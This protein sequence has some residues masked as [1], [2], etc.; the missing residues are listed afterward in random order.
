MSSSSDSSPSSSVDPSSSQSIKRPRKSSEPHRFV[1][2]SSSSS[3]LHN[4]STLTSST[5]L[6]HEEEVSSLSTPLPPSPLPPSSLPSSTPSG[7]DPMA[8]LNLA[9]SLAMSNMLSQSNA[10]MGVKAMATMLGLAG[11]QTPLTS[12][13]SLSTLSSPL[14]SLSSLS[15]LGSMGLGGGRSQLDLASLLNQNRLLSEQERMNHLLQE[16]LNRTSA[17][18]EEMLRRNAMSMKRERPPNPSIV[19]PIPRKRSAPATVSTKEIEE[20]KEMM[21]RRLHDILNQEFMEEDEKEVVVK[22]EVEREGENE[23]PMEADSTQGGLQSASSAFRAVK[24]RKSPLYASLSPTGSD[25]PSTPPSP[26]SPSTIEAVREILDN[27]NRILPPLRPDM[28]EDEFNEYLKD[29]ARWS[30]LLKMKAKTTATTWFYLHGD[31]SLLQNFLNSAPISMEME[32][33]SRQ[34]IELNLKIRL[35]DD[36]IREL[37]SSMNEEEE[38]VCLIVTPG[39]TTHLELMA[40]QELFCTSFVEYFRKRGIA[41]ISEF[42]HSNGLKYVAQFFS[43]GQFVASYLSPKYSDLLDYLN[44]KHPDKFLLVLINRKEE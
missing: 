33:G 9:S 31:Q 34:A 39:G 43:P 12:L 19:P 32:G 36:K 1:S 27:H 5:S 2:P 35:T 8:F 3:L 37:M 22:V 7:I 13:S 20:F 44:N 15:S 11:Q 41:G 30:G 40:N 25:S 29:G 14:S 6:S 4:L 26:L 38:R 42:T 28:T 17:L 18:N 24:G 23:V 16:N 21:Q 10:A